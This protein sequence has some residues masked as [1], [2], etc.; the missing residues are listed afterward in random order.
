MA[1]SEQQYRA[2]T[3]FLLSAVTFLLAVIATTAGVITLGNVG[4][5]VVEALVWVGL[6]GMAAGAVTFFTATRS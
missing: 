2:S 5:W 6:I 3:V 4:A 1:V